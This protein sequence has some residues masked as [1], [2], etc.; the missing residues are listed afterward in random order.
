MG[1]HLPFLNRAGRWGY[2][3]ELI[4]QLCLLRKQWPVSRLAAL[5]NKSLSSRNRECFGWCSGGEEYFGL[6]IFF[7]FNPFLVSL[8]VFSNVDYIF[9]MVW[10]MYEFGIGVNVSKCRM[11]REG[12]YCSA[13]LCQ[14]VS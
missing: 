8:F 12:D 10:G 14:L 13:L 11:V 1:F 2:F 5:Q 3:I 4:I 9:N 7:G 6:S